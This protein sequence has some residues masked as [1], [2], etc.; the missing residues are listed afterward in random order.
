MTKYIIGT[1]SE[2]DIPL[3]PSALG[4][5]SG[6]YYHLGVTEEVLQKERDELLSCS[7]E[8]IRSLK[9]YIEN[10]LKDENICVVGTQSKVEA[11]RELFGSTEN[12]I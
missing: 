3:S 1:L 4:S 11:C 2:L 6:K 8:N 12:L 7:D 5:R 9:A 10:A